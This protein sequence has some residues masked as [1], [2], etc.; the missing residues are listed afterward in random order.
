MY[1]YKL[2]KPESSKNMK[3][4][5]VFYAIVII[6][7]SIL[8]GLFIYGVTSAYRGFEKAVDTCVE[9]TGYSK[10]YCIEIAS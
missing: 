10:E 2:P 4:Y 8:V 3:V 6:V 5:L 9:N 1:N 7:A